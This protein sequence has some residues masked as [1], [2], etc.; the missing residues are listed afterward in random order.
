MIGGF[1]YNGFVMETVTITTKEYNSLVFAK[2]PQTKK[3]REA[4]KASWD[5]GF[6]LFKDSFGKGSSV[7]IV[8]KMRKAWR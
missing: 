8:K 6:G 4:K 7:N 5:A 1:W 3:A 2:R